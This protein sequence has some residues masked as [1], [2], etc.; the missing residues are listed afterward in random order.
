[1][2]FS[3]EITAAHVVFVDAVKKAVEA[4]KEAAPSAYRRSWQLT[5]MVLVYLV[6]QILRS[7]ESLNKLLENPQAA[8]KDL[9]LLAQKLQ[10]PAR[11][12]AATLKQRAD[13]RVRDNE[14]DEFN[15][16]FKRQDVLLG[17]RDRARDN[18]SL[19]GAMKV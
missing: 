2:I 12:A 9:V 11:M 7:D 17:L 3:E 5:R 10:Q 16:E 19:I 4:E 14:P 1:M 15:V 13:Q 8:T 18:Y 6:G